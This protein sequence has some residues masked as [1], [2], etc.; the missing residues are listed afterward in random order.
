M[1]YEQA[2]RQLRSGIVIPN[3]TQS[4]N[5]GIVWVGPQHF[6]VTHAPGVTLGR[7][8]GVRLNLVISRRQ[9]SVKRCHEI[10]GA[11]VGEATVLRIVNQ[12]STAGFW[13]RVTN[14]DPDGRPKVPS[15]VT[16]AQFDAGAIRPRHPCHAEAARLLLE[17]GPVKITAKGD[18]LW[19]EAKS[20]RRR[21]K[22][23]AWYRSKGARKNHFGNYYFP[24]S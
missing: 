8:K 13:E 22:S 5:F 10:I 9:R 7:N 17:R 21:Q 11:L 4:H 3:D 1:T 20:Y 6:V 18:V 2:T 15:V 19:A 24:V 16:L 12:A 23:D 14:G